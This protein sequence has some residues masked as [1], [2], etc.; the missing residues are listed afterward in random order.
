VTGF[1]SKKDGG[2]YVKQK[3]LFTNRNALVPEKLMFQRRGIS[4]ERYFAKKSKAPFRER[5]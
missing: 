5:R 1:F 2:F 3:G 4:T